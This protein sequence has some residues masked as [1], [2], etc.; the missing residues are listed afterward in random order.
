VTASD[1]RGL[2][3]SEVNLQEGYGLSEDWPLQN[4][5]SIYSCSF[6]LLSILGLGAWW[7]KLRHCF[8]V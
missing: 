7:D 4:H 6:D 5:E 1:S 8:F 2:W 3:L